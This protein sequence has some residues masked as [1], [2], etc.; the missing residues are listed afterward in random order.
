MILLEYSHYFEVLNI[1]SLLWKKQTPRK[2]DYHSVNAALVNGLHVAKLGDKKRQG[3]TC[4]P[5]MPSSSS[6]SE[7]NYFRFASR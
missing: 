4:L 1:S 2:E 6:F 7:L 3:Q 5:L